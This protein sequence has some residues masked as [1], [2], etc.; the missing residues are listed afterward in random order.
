MVHF[1]FKCGQHN[2]PFFLLPGGLHFKEETPFPSLFSRKITPC[3]TFLYLLKWHH[4][5]FAL[6][7]LTI[8]WVIL[9]DWLT[10]QW[11][12]S[13]HDFILFDSS[14]S[15]PSNGF[16]LALHHHLDI[17]VIQ[18][19]GFNV[20]PGTFTQ[21]ALTPILE[22]T[23]TMAKI[24]FKPEDRGC[25]FQSEINLEHWPYDFKDT[26]NPEKRS[27]GGRYSMSNCLYEAVLEVYRGL[28]III[29]EQLPTFEVGSNSRRSRVSAIVL[30]ISTQSG[31][32]WKHIPLA[33]VVA[34]LASR[35][36]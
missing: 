5:T 34:L 30:R 29:W 1:G 27:E 3:S 19:Q 11:V 23:T 25:Y 36:F 21:I 6:T 12:Y 24:R 4:V 35:S 22:S 14:I 18:Q 7:S 8:G 20:A 15:S 32:M 17:P 26:L 13:T 16:V 31:S 10:V 2:S 28:L 33:K 9:A